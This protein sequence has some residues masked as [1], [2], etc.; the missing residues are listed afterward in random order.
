[1]IK[2]LIIAMLSQPFSTWNIINYMEFWS[3]GDRM[4]IKGSIIGMFSQP[5]LK[6]GTLSNSN[7]LI[8]NLDN[9]NTIGWN[10]RCYLFGR[11]VIS[12]PKL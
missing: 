7:F 12:L 11:I 1:M 3:S 8:V 10:V 4:M 2:G 9:I 5:F 6:V